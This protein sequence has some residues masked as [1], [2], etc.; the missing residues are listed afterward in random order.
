MSPATPA[1]TSKRQRDIPSLDGLRAFSILLVILS[2]SAWYFPSWVEACLP[3]RT[4]VGNGRHGVAV[5]F[6]ISG[7]LIT[8]LLMREREKTG[9]ISLP[10][11]YFRR[12]FRI[13]PPFY[14]LIAVM[15]ILW[16]AGIVPEH[17]PSFLAAATYTWTYYPFA[18]GYEIAHTWSLSIEEQ[19]YL[20]W[21]LA[22]LLWHQAS[23]SIRLALGLILVMP[24]LRVAVYFAFPSLRGHESYMLQEWTDSM[25][26]GCLLALIK[27]KPRWQQWHRRWLNSW[28]AGTLAVI[29]LFG[30]PWLIEILP[31]KLGGFFG[32]SV[33]YSITAIC[34]GGVLV[35]VVESPHSPAAKLLQLPIVRHL[36]V[37]SYSLYLWQQIFTSHEFKLLP[38]GWLYAI[39]V[40]EISYWLVEQPALRLRNRL[41]KRIQFRTPSTPASTTL[42]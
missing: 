35:Y 9:T 19:F 21:P 30:V 36:G 20:F 25:M 40:A 32:L 37:L 14:V 17:L 3:F 6:V 5:F 24:F 22:L 13:F 18:H 27:S 33:G 31:G 12:I 41:E 29:G 34:V 28:T 16:I 8:T 39:A 26:V 15:A 11:F 2:H 1:E 4:I 7:Y 38:W 23:K 42:S 10:R